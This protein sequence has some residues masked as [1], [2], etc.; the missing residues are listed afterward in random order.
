MVPKDLPTAGKKKVRVHAQNAERHRLEV[1]ARDYKRNCLSTIYGPTM[2]VYAHDALLALFVTVTSVLCS[3]ITILQSATSDCPRELT[4]EICLTLEQFVSNPSYSQSSEI[5]LSMQSG[6]HDLSTDFLISSNT[7]NF[8]MRS[9]GATIA[10]D[11]SSRSL[12]M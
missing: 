12:V 10:C 8:T 11:T 7:R 4:G 9:A 1:W 5:V 6:R 2:K 3:E